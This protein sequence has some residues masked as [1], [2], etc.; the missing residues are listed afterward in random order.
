MNPFLI[1]SKLMMIQLLSFLLFVALGKTPACAALGQDPLKSTT[2]PES[3]ERNAWFH[4]RGLSLELR[5]A[6]EVF[7]S[8]LEQENRGEAVGDGPAQEVDWE[9]QTPGWESLTETVVNNV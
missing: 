9:T 6:V 5:M 4:R 8:V 7:S 1:V 2:H 3:L